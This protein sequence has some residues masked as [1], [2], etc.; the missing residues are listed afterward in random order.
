M[1][2]PKSSTNLHEELFSRKFFTGTWCLIFHVTEHMFVYVMLC[3]DGST[4]SISKS[5]K[6][7]APAYKH[8]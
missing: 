3:M 8:L 5:N 2:N 7:N 4:S 6:K 1:Y